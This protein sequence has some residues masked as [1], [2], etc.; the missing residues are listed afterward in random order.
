MM[1]GQKNEQQNSHIE[2]M[3]RQM[4]HSSR[5][6]EKMV[7][8]A[9]IAFILLAGYGFFLV[10]SV[11]RDMSMIAQFMDK[12]LREDMLHISESVSTMSQHV[13][14]MRKS[15][16]AISYQMEPLQD[17]R[18]MLAEIQKL[19]DSLGRING[20]MSSMD[21]SVD[22]MNHSMTSLD[23][24]MYYMGKDVDDMNDSF[25]SPVKMVKRFMPW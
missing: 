20:T 7:F 1:K 14:G 19:D 17:L 5:R 22:G 21:E 24:S 11:T 15:V 25:S 18:P 13:E 12:K 6:W 16:A 4:E 10:F 23:D 8:P 9:M 3:L 2:R